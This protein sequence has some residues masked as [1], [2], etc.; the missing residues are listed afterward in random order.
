MVRRNANAPVDGALASRGCLSRGLANVYP[1]DSP[2]N[3]HGIR[4]CLYWQMANVD[5]L[6]DR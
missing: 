6:Q 2:D 5:N 3:L 4:K 1:K